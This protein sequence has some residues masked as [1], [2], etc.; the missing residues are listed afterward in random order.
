MATATD[1]ALSN[2][3]SSINQYPKISRE[4]ELE[5]WGQW[6][7]HGKRAARE[8]LIRATL[9]YSVSLAMKYGRYGIH[10]SELIAEGN[11]GL[12]QALDKFDATRGTRF[13]TYAAYWMRA[14][15][16]EY[17]IR[18]WSLVGFGTGPLR[19][20][21]FFKLRRERA[22]IHNLVGEGEEANALLAARF[23]LS[24]E[25]ITEFMRR[26]EARDSSLNV[27]VS[28]DSTT[29]LVDTL[30]SESESHEQ[31]ITSAESSSLGR[32]IVRKA[33]LK[34]DHRERFIAEH[35]LMCDPEEELSL[36]EIGSYFGVTRERTRQLELRTRLKLR[37]QICELIGSRGLSRADLNSAA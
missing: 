11:F 22:R 34:L 19:S 17:I 6:K 14:Y 30:P 5:L 28:D 36:A 32:E 15:I 25:K 18:C 26:L 10:L 8:A 1:T 7:V 9:R 24:T 23:G 2:Y 3:I 33:L 31:S 12:V 37:T 35:R 13:V 4:Q 16:L 29:S 21:L 27:R 20:K